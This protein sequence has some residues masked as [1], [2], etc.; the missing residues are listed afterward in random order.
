[1]CIDKG[2]VLNEE[3]ETVLAIISQQGAWARTR[4]LEFG[5]AQFPR[6][7]AIAR[8]ARRIDRSVGKTL[9]EKGIHVRRVRHGVRASD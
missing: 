5:Y 6:I 8:A 7:T 4:Y 3:D 1:M 9:S 2:L